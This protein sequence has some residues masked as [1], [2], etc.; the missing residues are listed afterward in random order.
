MKWYLQSQ[1][2]WSAIQNSHRLYRWETFPFPVN[3]CTHSKVKVAQSCPTLR[4][5][6]FYSP[7]D[8]PG[9]N[10]GVGSLSLLHGIFPTQGLNPGLPHC[11]RILYQL[12][13]QG[14]PRILEWVVYPFSRGFSWLRNWTR[15]ALKIYV[16]IYQK[17]LVWSGLKAIIWT[18]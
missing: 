7:W 9:Q 4:H 3:S 18:V 2:H 14:S 17:N 5:H 16:K 1:T 12:S 10:I 6:G 8:S 15:K 11:R 13:H